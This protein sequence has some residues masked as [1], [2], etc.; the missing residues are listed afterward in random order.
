M[1]LES[2]FTARLPATEPQ[3]TTAASTP[4]ETVRLHDEM[5]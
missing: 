4:L 2:L 3:N 1:V 5:S